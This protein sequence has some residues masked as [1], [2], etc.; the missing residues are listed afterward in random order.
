MRE[1]GTRTFGRREEPRRL[2][3][4][5]SQVATISDEL[6][7]SEEHQEKA[8]AG[9]SPPV[10]ETPESLGHQILEIESADQASVA[11]QS[12]S[13]VGTIEHVN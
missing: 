4:P 9:Q 6:V 13:G 1:S 7:P 8:L 12:P 3:A 2:A 5:F 11:S 10:A